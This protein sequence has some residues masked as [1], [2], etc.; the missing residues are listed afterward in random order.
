MTKIIHYTSGLPRSCSTL[1]QNLIAQ[2]PDCHATATSGIA[3][4]IAHSRHYF[5]NDEFKC[6]IS[7]DDAET[8][9]HQFCLGGIQNSYNSVTDKKI[10][11]DKSRAWI[12]M[13]DLLFKIDPNAKIIVPVRDVRG[14]MASME[15]KRR[16]HPAPLSSIEKQRPD[17]WT[18]IAQ[19]VQGWLHTP[20]VGIAIN[21]LAEAVRTYKDRL[22]F[23]HAE[24]LTN[25]PQKVMIG[26]WAYLGLDPI[27]HCID[28]VEQTTKEIE[29]GW[30]Y[31][32]HTIRPKITPL[33]PDWDEVLGINLSKQINQQY[34]WINQL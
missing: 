5:E 33:V 20:P 19:R 13:L 6:Q 22:H 29:M 18:T 34:H 25:N 17:Q 30:P 7:P 2:H 15:K 31:G 27:E 10:V 3:E 32:D 16:S 26:V 8:Q 23:V 4:I 12:G 9:Y 11:I 24:D 1:L 21:R 14:I 28:S